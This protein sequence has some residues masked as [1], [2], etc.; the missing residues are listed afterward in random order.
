MGHKNELICGRCGL[1]NINLDFA[2]Y[3]ETD[4]RRLFCEKCKDGLKHLCKFTKL[5]L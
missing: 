4:L 1:N 2:W 3:D 5:N